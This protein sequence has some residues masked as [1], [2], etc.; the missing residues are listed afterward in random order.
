V[1]AEDLQASC[2]QPPRAVSAMDG[3]AVRAADLESG[4]A[5][6]RVIGAAPAGRPFGGA[7]GPGETVRIFTG[8]ILPA[9]ADA[10]ALQE[11]ATVESDIVTL[12]GAVAP[13]R[14]V[15]PAGLDL[16]AGEV[17]LTAGRRLTPR[18]V[19]LAASIN[20]VWLPVRRRPRLAVLATGDELVMPGTPLADAQIVS[21]NSL[22][23]AGLVQ[24]FGGTTTDLGIVPD[25]PGALAA[26]ADGLAGF[27]LVVTL[28]GASVGDHDLV[29]SA[30]GERGLELAF[31]RIAMRPGKP[32]LFGRIAGVPLLGLPGNP[33]STGVCTVIFVRA[34]IQRMLGLEP[35]LP[36]TRA[37]LGRS[38]DANDEREEYLRARV[39]RL[40]NG[41][42]EATPWPRQ[43]SSMLAIFAGSDG[44]VRRAARAPA[45]AA[46]TEVD[47]LL[48][49]GEGLRI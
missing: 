40:P 47:L 5:Q 46:G 26:I 25:D 21:S 38:L 48:F 49:E 17:V 24:G 36:Y 14:H 41:R 16:R 20:R 30:L 9:G 33:V 27:D 15:R 43:D 31:W 10:I 11:D 3:Y 18:D 19:A 39:R 8:G 4:T 2:D 34:A 23:V 1:L 12:V 13:G 7:V 44:L 35:T 45:M 22:L 32:L 6:L 37:V 28:G 29:R 42:L